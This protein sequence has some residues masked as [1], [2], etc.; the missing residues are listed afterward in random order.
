MFRW[1]TAL[2]LLVLAPG[3]PASPVAK[4]AIALGGE[5]ANPVGRS[6]SVLADVDQSLSREAAWQAFQV[7]RF[8]PSNSSVLAFGIGAA[9]V[10]IHMRVHNPGPSPVTRILS[11]E[12]AWL[13]EVSFH[14]RHDGRWVGQQRLGDRLPYADRP[15]DSIGLSFEREFP[16]GTTDVL[17]R[18]ATPDPM[19]FPLYVETEAEL[20]DR[21][22]WTAYSYGFLYGFLVALI[23]Y[24]LML[25]IGLR[26]SRYLLYSVY[27]AFFLLMN[28]SYT[29]HAY[30][31]WWSESPVWAQWSQPVLMMLYASSGL[32]FAISFLQTRHY[33]PR[34]HQAVLGYIGTGMVMLGLMVLLDWQ[35]PALLLAFSF[36]TL[37]TVIMLA[38]GVMS[39]RAGLS[40]A[41]YFLLAAVSAMVGAALT[42]LSVWGVIPFSIWTYR[43]VDIGMLLDATLLALALTYQFR[44]G[45]AQ[46]QRAERLASIDPLT[47]VNNRRAFYDLSRPLWSEICQAD[48]RLSVILMDLDHFKRINDSFGHAAG[49]A[50]LRAAADRV[51]EIIRKQ[52]IIARWGG[53]E[54]IVLLPDTALPEAVALAERL[55]AKLADAPVVVDGKQVP[56]TASFGVAARDAVVFDIEEL[57]NRADRSLYRAKQDGRNRVRVPGD[58]PASPA[59]A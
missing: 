43:A 1:L 18:V 59:G 37:F 57:I 27:L 2:L 20:G 12:T 28:I 7:G 19:V 16:A 21:T 4:G 10:W 15:R 40:S 41:H 13:D 34:V 58:R 54:F 25:F 51:Q 46:R 5:V 55:R 50:V 9:P 6:L 45:Q 35:A 31:W 39:V 14:F 44:I 3:I 36:V 8:Q 17:V 11:V 47:G 56:I 22:L 42:A 26:H 52:D 29:G 30:A 49:D 53:E 24:N 48:C 33:F 23:V 38:L 32:F